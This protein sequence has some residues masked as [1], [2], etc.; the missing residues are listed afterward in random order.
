MRILRYF[1]LTA[2]RQ[3]APPPPD[4]LQEIP[5]VF[6]RGGRPGRVLGLC[7][8]GR[9]R[10]VSYNFERNTTGVLTDTP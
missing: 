4:R 8:D 9:S 7:A 6:T 3:V 1:D 5:A 10:P 2:R